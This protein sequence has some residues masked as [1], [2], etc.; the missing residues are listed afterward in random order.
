MPSATF[1]NAVQNGALAVSDG[2]V[3]L[4][5][6]AETAAGVYEQADRQAM[7]TAVPEGRGEPRRGSPGAAVARGRA[8]PAAHRRRAPAR[9]RRRLR[10]RGLQLGGATAAGWSGMAE[11]SYTGTL[12][13]AGVAVGYMSGSLDTAA[14]GAHRAS[15]A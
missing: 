14:G 8:R 3:A 10:G 9:A 15:R 2:V 6:N 4:G 7:P 1:S 13:R 5:S 12:S 11:A